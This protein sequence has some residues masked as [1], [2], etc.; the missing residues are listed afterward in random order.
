MKDAKTVRIFKKHL[1]AKKMIARVHLGSRKTLELFDETY[2]RT[3]STLFE[4]P[5]PAGIRSERAPNGTGVTF[6]RA[7]FE[8]WSEEAIREVVERELPR[9]GL[10]VEISAAEQRPAARRLN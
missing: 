10:L 8:P 6:V 7:M 4:T 5:R 2:R 3:L 1:G 9:I